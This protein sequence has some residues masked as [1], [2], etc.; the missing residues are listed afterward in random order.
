MSR[1][2]FFF[3]GTF[4]LG[5]FTGTRWTGVL[6]RLVSGWRSNQTILLGPVSAWHDLLELL[7]LFLLRAELNHLPLRQTCTGMNANHRCRRKT[8]LVKKKTPNWKVGLDNKCLCDNDEDESIVKQF[9]QSALQAW[10][11]ADC[12][13]SQPDGMNLCCR[14][15]KWYRRSRELCFLACSYCGFVCIKGALS[16]VNNQLMW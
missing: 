6:T 16:N 12:T 11:K 10:R 8:Q 15:C 1:D 13:L 5:G 3:A 14:A 2:Y 4:L 7:F 9:S